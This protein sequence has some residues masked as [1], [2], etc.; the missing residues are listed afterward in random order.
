[1]FVHLLTPR[2]GAPLELSRLN[3][4]TGPNQAGKSAI[5]KD[6]F[7]LATGREPGSD[8]DHAT[9]VEPVVLEDMQ[10]GGT[11]EDE[12]L[13]KGQ[14][15]PFDSSSSVFEGLGGDLRG[16]IRATVRNESW[17]IVKRPILHARSVLES[18]LPDVMMLRTAYLGEETLDQA[19]S[20]CAGNSPLEPVRTLLQML[21]YAPD[22]THAELD[23]AFAAA[24]PPLGL[25]LDATQN[26][27]LSLRVAAEFPA[28]AGVVEDARAWSQLPKLDD[29]GRGARN[30]AAVALSV[31]L[32]RGRIM[33]IDEPD[34]SLQPFAARQLGRW[35]ATAAVENDCQLIVTARS[36][37]MI[38]GMLERSAD[39]TLLRAQR[40]HRGTRISAVTPAVSRDVL[41]SPLLSAEDAL[42]SL[43]RSGAILVADPLEAAALSALN[44]QRGGADRWSVLCVLDL[45]HA[46][47]LL[48]MLRAAGLPTAVIGQLA[49]LQDKATST[50]LLQAACR[51]QAPMNWLATRDQLARRVAAMDQS[52]MSAHTEAME[53]MLDQ[54]QQGAAAEVEEMPDVERLNPW[55]T[56]ER[57]GIAA[58]PIDQRPWVEQLLEELKTAGV[59]LAPLQ[60][61]ANLSQATIERLMKA[62]RAGQTPDRIA[63]LYTEVTQYLKSP[64][65]PTATGESAARQ[66]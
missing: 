61:L 4:L 49:T 10:Y 5:L 17:N 41:K 66:A 45:A 24:F 3:V 40:D 1:M 51:D 7:R 15:N 32:L 19:A 58:I 6:I 39:V 31:L 43:Q 18:E 55:K 13:L 64:T 35:L 12:E 14:G 36:S 48:R 9:H 16:V 33:I 27:R 20:S 52:A 11:H 2:V 44:H 57:D 29:A 65:V 47:P 21:R 28:P 38:A 26:V 46:G 53:R 37:A 22:D 59:F 8:A 50:A 23:G 25:R 54:L 56:I 42:E 62:I 63:L 60:I 34:A 30:F